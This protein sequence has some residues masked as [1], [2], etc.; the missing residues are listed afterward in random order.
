MHNDPKT[1]SDVLYA[2]ALI[3]RRLSLDNEKLLPLAEDV[4]NVAEAEH[5]KELRAAS[6]RT[7]SDPLSPIKRRGNG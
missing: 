5:T 7:A 6:T 2:A 1:P 3:L 4:K